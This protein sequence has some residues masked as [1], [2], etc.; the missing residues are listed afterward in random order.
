M[1]Y[2]ENNQKGFTIVELIATIMILSLGIL[3]IY[4]AFFPFIALTSNISHRLTASYLTQDGLE[5]IRNMR[6][7]NFVK[8]GS[9][10]IIG[11]S[12][13][14][15]D[16]SLGCQ[17]DY[18]TGTLAETPNNRLI[19]YNPNNFLKINTDG[20]YSYDADLG[21]VDTKF[22]RKITIS[23]PSADIFKVDVLVMWDYNNQ[24]FSFNTEEYI[25]DWY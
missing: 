21:T 15:L 6:D 17:A 18:K 24:S 20:F 13:G 12:A 9:G 1:K 25:Y 7:T 23:Q 5:I 22:K 11:W 4:N 14:L 2:K 10:Q 19:A 16:C 3:G 8:K